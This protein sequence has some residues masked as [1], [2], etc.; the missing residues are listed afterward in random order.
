MAPAQSKDF[1]AIQASIECRFTLKL[2]YDIIIT[3]NLYLEF[4]PFKT[5]GV[6]EIDRNKVI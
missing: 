1:L 2:V 5:P 6:V 4:K 3:Y